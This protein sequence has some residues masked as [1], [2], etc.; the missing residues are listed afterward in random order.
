MKYLSYKWIVVACIRFQQSLFGHIC[1][2]EISLQP[3]TIAS[4]SFSIC[5]YLCRDTL[6]A[7]EAYG[8]RL[9]SCVIAAPIHLALL[10]TERTIG[11]LL[12]KYASTGAFTYI[13]LHVWTLF[14]LCTVPVLVYVHV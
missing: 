1:I 11:L 5:E 10:S 9:P 13:F 7:H 3:K 2:S 12:S 14:F 4:V 6:N 8:I